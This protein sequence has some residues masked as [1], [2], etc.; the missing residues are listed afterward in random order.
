MVSRT[1]RVGLN[2]SNTAILLRPRD[3]PKVK[4]LLTKRISILHTH[5]ETQLYLE[6]LVSILHARPDP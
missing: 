4:Q 2:I 3:L 1:V 5:N 6:K